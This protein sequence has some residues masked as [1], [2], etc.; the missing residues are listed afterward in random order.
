M[1]RLDG[2]V[3]ILT[4]GAR[5]IGQ[6]CA[7]RMAAEGAKVVIGDLREDDTTVAA[8]KEAGG[9]AVQLTLDVRKR[10]DWQQLVGE[11]VDR[12]GK[13]DL[14]VNN[15]GIVNML[16]PDD[17]VGMSDEGWDSVID[18][19]LR[20]T[21]LGMQACIPEM[22]KVGRGS[23]VN[24]SSLAAVNGNPN[25]A[26]YSAAK[27]GILAL[28]RQVAFDFGEDLIRVNAVCPGTI[29]TPLLDD[30]TPE[31]V[32]YFESNHILKRLGTG[33][34]VAGMVAFLLSDDA[35]FVTGQSLNCDGGWSVN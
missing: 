14:L 4:G 34:D 28:T 15:A 23:I 21:W 7:E 30:V 24:M 13:V 12:Y 1:N 19:H 10:E 2:K 35:D 11:A 20:G 5:G 16:S 33:A 18:T 27:G 9:E 26:S 29:R 22:K 6:A 32:A 3:A 8:I 17:V 25:L 31:M